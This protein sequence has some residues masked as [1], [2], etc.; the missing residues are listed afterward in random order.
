MC[1]DAVEDGAS[2]GEGLLLIHLHH[3]EK[4][5]KTCKSGAT[6]HMCDRRC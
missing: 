3:E 1:L 4:I 2:Q 5:Q 6:L